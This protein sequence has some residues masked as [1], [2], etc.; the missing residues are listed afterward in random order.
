MSARPKE[1]AEPPGDSEATRLCHSNAFALAVEAGAGGAAGS[2]ETVAGGL[3]AETGRETIRLTPHCTKPSRALAMARR[4][5]RQPAAEP[6][7]QYG[8]GLNPACR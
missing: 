8:A 6:L 1:P 3:A 4:L 2:F 7:Q 5:F